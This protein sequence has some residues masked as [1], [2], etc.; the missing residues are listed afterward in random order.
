MSSTSL[1]EVYAWA[2][3][4]HSPP[5]PSLPQLVE[6]SQPLSAAMSLIYESISELMDACVK[7]LRKYNKLDASDL[8]VEQVG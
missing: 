5:A 7:E 3:R 2:N 8:T 4:F 1:E 6:L